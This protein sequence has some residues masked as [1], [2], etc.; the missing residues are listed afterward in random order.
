MLYNKKLIHFRV[1]SLVLMIFFLQVA[2]VMAQ[3]A[4]YSAER[5]HPQLLEVVKPDNKRFDLS[6]MVRWNQTL[7]GLADKPWNAWLYELSLKE[8][9]YFNAIESIPVVFEGRPD[10]EAVD[11]L[12]SCFYVADERATKVVKITVKQDTVTSGVLDLA[13]SD[14]VSGW[15]N[16]GIEGLAVDKRDRAIYIAKEREPAR[17]FRVLPGDKAVK[18]FSL[19]KDISGED[20]SDMKIEDGNLYLLNRAKYRILKFSLKTRKHT[21]TFDY[22]VVLNADNQKFYSGARYPMAEALLIDDEEVWI[23]LDNNGRGFNDNNPY[24][25]DARLNGNNPVI[26]R[27]KR[28]QHF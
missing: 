6:G 7:Y 26:I 18:E 2:S 9:A 16:A 3:P 17:L 24:V 14:D 1:A 4:V 11:R 10:F 8:D 12:D 13:W 19:E 25:R 27:F 20:I 15:G 23:G 28:P 21:A 22:S 5:Y